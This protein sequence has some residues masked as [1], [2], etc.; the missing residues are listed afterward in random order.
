[1]DV[2]AI[3]EKR[4]IPSFFELTVIV[5]KIPDI[6]LFNLENTNSVSSLGFALSILHVGKVVSVKD[7][8][9]TSY[10]IEI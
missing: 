8:A 1:M 5:K 7:A 6:A 10:K 2:L 4:F 9:N 3:N